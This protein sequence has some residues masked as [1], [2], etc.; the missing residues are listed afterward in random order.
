MKK[1]VKQL[2]NS[3]FFVRY[4]CRVLSYRKWGINKKSYYFEKSPFLKLNVGCLGQKI[5]R[6]VNIDSF[7]TRHGIFVFK[8]D[9]MPF[10]NNSVKFIRFNPLS[11]QNRQENIASIISEF[12]RVLVPGGKLVIPSTK[13]NNASYS[14]VISITSKAGFYEVSEDDPF[15]EGDERHFLLEEKVDS[16]ETVYDF[17]LDEY[18]EFIDD[19]DNT[20]FVLPGKS[21]V[22]IK[23]ANV[24][25]GLSCELPYQDNAFVKVV[26]FF[27]FQ[28]VAPSRQKA[29]FSEICR[30]LKP[31]G[32]AVVLLRNEY[33][34]VKVRQFYDKGALIENV[35]KYT[36]LNILRLGVHNI[37]G[38]SIMVANLT[39]K[40][41][42]LDG[43]GKTDDKRKV[44]VIGDYTLH[45]HDF[46]H[47]GGQ[48][49]GIKEN[50]YDVV[51]YDIYRNPDLNLLAT[52]I[53]D[54]KPDYI[55]IG[56]REGLDP[57]R[58]IY[59]D[60]KHLD[61]KILY[62][63]CDPSTPI[64]RDL[65]GV[66]DF[67]FLSN[68][69]QI[70]EY[71][72][73]FGIDNVYYLPQAFSPHVMYRCPMPEIYDIAFAGSVCPIALHESRKRHLD[74][75]SSVYNVERT[76]K[77]RTMINELYNSSKLVYGGSDFPYELY[78]S[79]RFFIALGCGSAY[80][81]SKFEGIEKLVE[82]RKH[83]LWFESDD[84]MMELAQYYIESD[85]ER[86]TL[87]ENAY[88]LAL[89]KHTYAK[90]MKNM[91]DI[92]DGKEKGFNGFLK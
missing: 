57:V 56:V 65:K 54:S 62:W 75:L 59:D 58:E 70:D 27:A 36:S 25:D 76:N 34:E 37:H 13:I 21:A 19:S 71:K 15:L 4:I 43:I 92:V 38:N 41:N 66:I 64:K 72:K 42:V 12:R 61:A 39:K 87:R 32:S 63:Y 9:K 6:Y 5:Y 51:A 91:F 40:K 80:L 89:E 1:N 31:G 7:R 10:D 26:V 11:V 17:N 30:I 60:I 73:Q 23:A 85:R 50:G 69:G 77:V 67:M 16:T 8:F 88:R 24:C 18:G 52:A 84:E 90:R 46:F 82:N 86:N 79:N 53:K 29:L 45:Q 78:T 28:F 2:M 68:S 48:I 35:D 83:V 14:E 55:L 3:L 44:F 20:L 49:R 47:W 81:C 22:K 33:C 74:R